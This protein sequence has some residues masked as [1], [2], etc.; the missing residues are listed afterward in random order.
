MITSVRM[1]ST[2]MTQHYNS[3]IHACKVCI[4]VTKVRASHLSIKHDI[5]TTDDTDGIQIHW[6]TCNCAPHQL[7][8]LL[9]SCGRV[10]ACLRCVR[11]ASKILVAEKQK[12]TGLNRREAQNRCFSESVVE[13]KFSHAAMC[14]TRYLKNSGNYF[15]VFV[16]SAWLG[17]VLRLYIRLHHCVGLADKFI[18]ES[19]SWWVACLKG[20][21]KLKLWRNLKLLHSVLWQSHVASAL[22]M[23]TPQC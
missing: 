13:A 6:Q 10:W 5:T 17:Y 23:W 21:S 16:T 19:L 11:I 18:W 20:G 3:E 15:N 14:D 22:K 2:N 4:L 1:L 9:L 7:A 8:Q 12:V